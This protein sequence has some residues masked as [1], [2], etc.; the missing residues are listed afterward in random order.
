MHRIWQA[1]GSQ[2]HRTETFKLSADPLFVEKVRDITGWYLHR[3]RAREFRNL[4][5]T[6]EANVPTQLDVHLI[7]DNHGTHETAMIRQRRSRDAQRLNVRQRV[8]F[9]SSLTAVLLDGLSEQPAGH[10]SSVCDR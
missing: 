10:S 9:A 4:L 1:F 7:L 2:P 3:R 5:D 8:R 6:I